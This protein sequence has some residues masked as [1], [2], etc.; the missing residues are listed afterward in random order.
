M[1][2]FFVFLFLCASLIIGVFIILNVSYKYFLETDIIVGDEQISVVIPNG[3][4]A[5]KL[6]QD[7]SADGTIKSDLR[8]QVFLRLQQ[9]NCLQVGEFE[10]PNYTTP[11]DLFELLCEE[12]SE[13]LF[14]ETERSFMFP[15]GTNI[16]QL[17]DRVEEL[18]FGD[19]ERIIS[20]SS[21]AAF[22]SSLGCECSSLEG[23]LFPNTYNFAADSTEEDL[24]RRFYLEY[25]RVW[26]RLLSE[27]LSALSDLEQMYDVNAEDLL[28]IA[29]LVEE[30]AV[31]EQERPIIARVF[32][33]RIRSGMRLQTDP[34]C[35]YH[36][37]YY[38]EVPSRNRCRDSSSRYSTYVIDGLP[39]TPITN[40]GEASMR[41][42][43]H[44]VSDPDVLY[45]VAMQDGSG[46]HMFSDT[47]EEHRA[48]IRQYLR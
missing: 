1:K 6:I 22:L 23:K 13:L 42:A 14:S 46:R 9:P 43:L 28:I 40:P 19:R 26:N 7:L 38:R 8:W 30:E 45:F 37:E 3:I 29:S 17:A 25:E 4:N 24:L 33:N 39:P 20:L 44:P 2:K 16:F 11:Q 27:D 48:N 21:D 12:S 32:Y 34:T 47:Y 35:V 5:T 31:V 15:E 36:P 10:I 41:A 18:G